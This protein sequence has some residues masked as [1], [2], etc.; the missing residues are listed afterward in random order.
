MPPSVSRQLAER[1]AAFRYQDLPP[2]SSPTR[3]ST[4]STRSGAMLVASAPKYPASR[5]IMRFVHELG[6]VAESSLVGQGN[7]DLVR[8]RG[9]RQRNARLLLRH[10]AASR[11]RDPARPGGGRADEPRRRREAAA[12]TASA[13]SPPS[14]SASRWRRASPTRSIPSRST[15]V[16]FTRARCAVAFGAAAAAGYLFRLNAER[17]AVAL[18]LAM[19]QASGL[20]AWANDPDRALAPAQP[21]AGRAQRHDGRVSRPT[22]LRR[23]AHALRRQVRRLHRLLGLVQPRRAPRGLG[24]PLSSARVRLQALLLLR[25]HA[26][27]ARRAAGTGRRPARSLPPTSTASCCASRRTAPT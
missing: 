16:A 24:R 5:I 7:E 20:L 13:C 27:G 21:W 10:R 15:T 14:C 22:R 23:S 19:Q 12:P 8:E 11:G 25:V 9:A 1:I 18:G 3:S 6:G 26:S 17:Q 4:S 2:T